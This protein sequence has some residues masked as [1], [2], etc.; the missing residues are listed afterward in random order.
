[1]SRG[2]EHSSSETQT[3]AKRLTWILVFRSLMM[4]A[5]LVA[6]VLVNVRDPTVLT[7]PP[8]ILV[9]GGVGYAFFIIL[10]GA[11]W[12]RW[13]R[14][15]WFAGQIYL[16]LLSD[17][18]VAT[19]LI[20]ATGGVDSTFVFLYSLSIINAA[21]LH[22]RTGALVI[23]AACA[24]A[25]G[26]L[27]VTSWMGY[28]LG[29]VEP[30]EISTQHVINSV[31]FNVSAMF[32]I[33][34]LASYVSEQMRRAGESLEATLHDLNRLEVL[35]SAVV[36]SLRSGLMAV[37]CGGRITLLNSAGQRLLGLAEDRAQ[38]QS[39]LRF[40][41]R[42]EGHLGRKGEARFET[43]T[44]NNGGAHYYDVS[45]SPLIAGDP[46]PRGSVVTFQDVTELKELEAAMQRS[47]RLAT[48]GRF[49]AGLAHEL[50]NPLGSMTGCVELLKR[51]VGASQAELDP[52][53]Q[54]RLFDVVLRETERLNG[55]V[56]SFLSYARPS[57][58]DRHHVQLG[59]LVRETAEVA[60]REV[61]DGMSC[62]LE[63][64]VVEGDVM[65]WGDVGQLKQLIWNL[66]RNGMQAA[67]APGRIRLTVETR[68]SKQGHPVGV[69]IVEDNG[70]GVEADLRTKV[71]DPFFT[72]KPEG[73]GL[74]LPTV[75]RIIEDHGG[76]VSIGES[77][78][79]GA[80]LEVVLPTVQVPDRGELEP[81]EQARID[82]DSEES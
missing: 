56:S 15:R 37:D 62:E 13:Y 32:L 58:P 27:V 36:S 17:V 29:F 38:G 81:H 82:T 31:V 35:H 77:S 34:F 66:L 79:G 8:Q 50:R 65:V 53:S 6:T 59:S 25:F 48:I 61:A 22:Y 42:L 9:Y 30:P 39:A 26:G 67:L 55:L 3:A 80:A 73:T 78:L 43:M 12:Q 10:I 16:Q 63:V 47:E 54:R 75:L 60:Q 76:S 69:L 23:G 57:P 70:A 7:A 52:D 49:A 5:L 46:D 21:V 51:S 45:V 68:R 74:G 19:T 41:P 4:C 72:T 24:L 20:V 14:N 33:A 44:R 64:A 1:M 18:L 40:F 11:L 71:F 28:G 2:K